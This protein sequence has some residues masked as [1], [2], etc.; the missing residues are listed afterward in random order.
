MHG[1]ITVDMCRSKPGLERIRR[2]VEIPIELRVKL[3]EQLLEPI[4][5][6][7]GWGNEEVGAAFIEVEH[8]ECP[9]RHYLALSVI[10]EIKQRGDERQP[11]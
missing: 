6:D 9:A 8:F 10:F 3:P 2:L 1:L 11:G 4:D 5:L 7:F